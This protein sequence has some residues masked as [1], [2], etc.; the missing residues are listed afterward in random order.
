MT[1]SL[2]SSRFQKHDENKN[3]IFSLWYDTFLF[4]DDVYIKSDF[5]THIA[6]VFHSVEPTEHP[7]PDANCAAPLFYED[8]PGAKMPQGAPH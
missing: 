4:N 7:P 6:I 3:V 5:E 1:R 2:Y 8:H